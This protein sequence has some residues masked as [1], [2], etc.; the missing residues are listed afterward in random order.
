M[1]RLFL[2]TLVAM[3]LVAGCAQ[4]GGAPS[5]DGADDGQSIDRKFDLAP[6][7]LREFN[8]DMA[9][10]AAFT[11]SYTSSANVQWEIHSHD[12]SKSTTWTQGQGAAGGNT[13]T[14]TAANTY[15]LAFTNAGQDFAV[16]DVSIHGD[17]T[18][19]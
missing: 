8:L 9:A 7:G 2:T 14:A 15:S 10:G 5:G 16:V 19:A 6:Q 4:S 13:F 1:L 12:G 17:F 11:F 3:T 18:E